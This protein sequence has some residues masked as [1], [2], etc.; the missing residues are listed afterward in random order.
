MQ[1]AR[2]YDEGIHSQEINYEPVAY[3]FKG[4]LVF[5]NLN[6]IYICVVYRHLPRFFI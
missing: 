6:S 1:Y 2:Y 5:F 3:F 4:I